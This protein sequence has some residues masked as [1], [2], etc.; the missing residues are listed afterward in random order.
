MIQPLPGPWGAPP[1]PDPPVE[2]RRAPLDSDFAGLLGA[3]DRPV[4]REDAE[5]PLDEA[6]GSPLETPFPAPSDFD[7]ATEE[8]S[9]AERFN[10]H[11]FFGESMSALDAGIVVT[12]RQQEAVDRSAGAAGDPL[13]EQSLLD[14]S[15]APVLS[16]R[17]GPAKLAEGIQQSTRRPHGTFRAASQSTNGGLASAPSATG[18]ESEA[19]EPAL[20]PLP[21]GRRL[22]D[23]AAARATQSAARVAIGEGERGL[24]VAA[25]AGALS[26]E[27]RVRL[28][29]E[30]AALL[31]RHGLVPGRIHIAARRVQPASAQENLT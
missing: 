8:D 7:A 29:D 25:F 22:L 19:A 13:A 10:E 24:S 11:G 3:G 26:A 20:E 30:I 14:G 16:N 15:D 12:A 27:E 21:S 28:R 31:S 17:S 9:A 6:A 18:G 2:P 1:R 4:A 23:A 5:V